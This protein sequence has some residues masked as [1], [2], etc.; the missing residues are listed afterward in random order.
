MPVH[1]RIGRAFG[2]TVIISFTHR[3]GRSA[4]QSFEGDREVDA[5]LTQQVVTITTAA[6]VKQR[7]DAVLARSTR[8]RT[9]LEARKGAAT[10]EGDYAAYDTLSLLLYDGAGDRYLVGE[11]SPSD[12]NCTLEKQ[13][14]TYRLSGVDKDQATRN[15]VAALLKQIINVPFKPAD[16]AGTPQDFLD[17]HK[18]GA[19]GLAHLTLD[20]TDINPVMQFA[21]SRATRRAA[22]TAYFNRGCPANEPVLKDDRKH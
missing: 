2:A 19:D 15:K 1:R 5:L 14:I 3:G 16:L 4:W 21:T 8:V 7:C 20:A 18:P 12:T 9:A 22:T 13:L 6:A 11:S 10:L 17:S